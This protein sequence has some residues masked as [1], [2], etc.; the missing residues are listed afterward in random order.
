MIDRTKES[1]SLLTFVVLC[2]DEPTNPH[3][4]QMN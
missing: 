2:T 4:W 1:G 3:T